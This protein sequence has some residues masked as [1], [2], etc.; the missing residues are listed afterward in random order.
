[1]QFPDTDRAAEASLGRISGM[2]SGLIDD[3]QLTATGLRRSDIVG[4]PQTENRTGR[5]ESDLAMVRLGIATSLFLALRSKHPPTASHCLRTAIAC[6][7]WCERLELDEDQ[8]DRIEVAAL[9]HDVGKIGIPDSILKKPGKLTREEQHTMDHCPALG[10]EIL[11][12]CTADEEL[13]DIIRLNNLWYGSRRDDDTPRGEQLPLGARMLAIVEAFD[14]MTT[15]HVYRPAMSRE[16]ALAELA[17]CAGTQFDPTLA[18]DY[19]RMLEARPEVA[20]GGIVNR[21][22]TTLK[23]CEPDNRWKSSFDSSVRIFN[24]T[25]T[26]DSFFRQLMVHTHDGVAFIDGHGVIRAWNIALQQ[27]SGVSAELACGMQWAPELIGLRD[28]QGEEISGDQCPILYCL[29]HSDHQRRQLRIGLQHE[30]TLVDVRV[31]AVVDS[32]QGSQGVVVMFQDA[33]QQANLEARVRDLNERVTLD[34]LTGVGNRAEFDRRLRESS[35]TA[36]DG[37]AGFSLIIC[38]ID[39]FKLINDTYGHPAGDEAIIQFAKIIS[40]H[41]REGDLVA[42]YGGE[43][44]VLLCPACDN[45]TAAKRAEAIRATLETTPLSFLENQS[46]TASFGV[47]EYQEGDTSESVLARSDRALLRAKD[48]GRNRVVQL[49]SGG[50]NTT[51]KSE[52]DSNGWFGWIERNLA[53]TKNCVL[54]STA[55]PV[56]LVVEK[57]RGFVADHHAEILRVGANE[58]EVRMTVRFRVRGRRQTDHQMDFHIKMQIDEQPTQHRAANGNLYE[59]TATTVAVDLK[60]IRIRDRRSSEVKNASKQVI[61]SLRS[62]LM[63]EVVR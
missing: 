15:D 41:S 27:L 42:R 40:D 10:V 51:T 30:T 54:L 58:L 45:A 36:R 17:R 29:N 39:R 49:G 37:G 57:L 34:P 7:A 20:H 12:G 61:A 28:A 19:Q 21:W 5:Y 62:Y 50:Y 8:R 33:S 2:L 26:V 11:R 16:R 46:I 23:Q 14:S 9:L 63:A 4:T 22:I 18:G 13:L 59:A 44:F 48:N 25:T 52:S 56:D 32:E 53:G 24:D 3:Q 6:S 60:P 55:V 1:M 47:T 35:D 43:E 38:D 31:S